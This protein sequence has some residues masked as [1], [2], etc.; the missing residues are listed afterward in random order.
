MARSY[1]NNAVTLNLPKPP[2]TP[3]RSQLIRTPRQIGLLHSLVAAAVFQVFIKWLI[4]GLRPHFYNVCKP[5]IAPGHI[6]NGFGK[7]MYDR[8]V[9]TGD[10]DKINDAL[11]SMPWGHST[12][13]F[14]AFV[15]LHL[16]L[17][18]KLKLWSDHHP[19]S[20]SS[21]GHTLPS[22]ARA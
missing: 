18:A 21:S 9:C 6:G 11:E 19:L 10:R 22:W 1:A 17:T 5:F 3:R 7:M 20:G 16:Y 14:A 2:A 13:A 4:G 8:T 12:A 15:F